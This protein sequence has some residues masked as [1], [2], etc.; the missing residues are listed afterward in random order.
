[1]PLDASL[2]AGVDTPV[3]L[4]TGTGLKSTAFMTELFGQAAT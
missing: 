1:M 2:E 4:L 3:M